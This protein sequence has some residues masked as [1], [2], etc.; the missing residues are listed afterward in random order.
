[1]FSVM[2]NGDVC[3]QLL[4]EMCSVFEV[5]MAVLLSETDFK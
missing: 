5:A 2:T 3:L 1:M 4:I